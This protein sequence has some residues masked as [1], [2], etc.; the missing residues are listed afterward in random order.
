MAR[1]GHGVFEVINQKH[2]AFLPE[3]E[4]TLTE[5]ARHAAAALANSQQIQQLLQVRDRL[6]RDAASQMPLMGT[7]IRSRVY[8]PR[9][10]A[11]A[12][13]SCGSIV[14]GNGTGRKSRVAKSITKARAS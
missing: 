6:T 5:L 1:Q 3:D 10:R 8:E 13:R 7:C 12:H 14:R 2:G 9:S 11:R 4:A